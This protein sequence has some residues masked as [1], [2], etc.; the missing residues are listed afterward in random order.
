[1]PRAHYFVLL[2]VTLCLLCS[3]PAISGATVWDETYDTAKI[4]KAKQDINIRARPTKGSKVLGV[5]KRGQTAT[6][7]AMERGWYKVIL[8]DGTTGYI[9]KRFLAHVPGAQP[10]APVPEPAPVK[11]PEPAVSTKPEPT[12]DPIA[13]PEPAP[14][15]AAPKPVA[16]PKPAPVQP[17]PKPAAEAAPAP[18][19]PAPEPVVE[20]VP[21]PEPAHEPKSAPEPAPT[22]PQ[23]KSKTQ[24]APEKTAAPQQPAPIQI[25]AD[26]AP[27]ASSGVD[28]VRIKFKNNALTGTAERSVAKGGHDC[29]EVNLEKSQWMEVWLTSPEDASMFEIFSPTGNT[30]CS[31]EIHWLGRSE[32]AGEYIIFVSQD[33]G[34]GPYTLKVQVK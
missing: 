28:C 21:A 9:Y 24:P 4:F 27:D 18:A 26:P 16:E 34:N 14:V 7:P 17:T 11:A 29:Y 12:P 22:T 23:Q 33:S 3:A 31:R 13:S 32:Q 25:P 1:M 5:M 20:P 15:Q 10:P 30:L 19:P 6:V 2:L 8:P